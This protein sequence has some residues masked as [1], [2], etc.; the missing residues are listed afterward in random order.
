MAKILAVTLFFTVYLNV[1]GCTDP[2]KDNFKWELTFEDNF[3]FF[4]ESKW[5]TQYVWGNR[6]NWANQELQWYVDENVRVEDGIL[7]LVVEKQSNYGKDN[8]GEKQFEYVSGMIC[9]A[10]S[11]TQAYGKWEMRVKFPFG[12]GYWPAFWLLPEQ[13]PTLPEIDVFEYF[14]IEE[15]QI[16]STIH[17]GVDYPN[18]SWGEYY[19]KGEPF[20]YSD[21]KTI[22]GEFADRWMVW[23]FECYPNKAVW[24]LDGKVIHEVTKGIPTAPMYM[25]ANV[26]V[27]DFVENDGF[28][29]D[30]K[31]PYVM[32]IDYIR[33]YKMV[34]L[35]HD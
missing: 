12:K 11:F 6:T 3:D 4:D 10:N 27:K 33:V 30:S 28:V 14:G 23:T 21:S 22:Q 8:E 32:E 16:S 25:I 34:P 18:Y 7:K 9:S 26:A 17:W 29:D 19:G 2:E 1:A 31:L 24:K 20:F 5:I 15:D 13:R 35:N